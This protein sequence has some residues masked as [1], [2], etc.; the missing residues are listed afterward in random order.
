MQLE[1]KAGEDKLLLDI[2]NQH[3]RID[4]NADSGWGG[5]SIEALVPVEKQRLFVSAAVLNTKAKQIDDGLYAAAELIVQNG[6][7]K[8]S[9]K[10]EFL[11]K[12][13]TG[14]TEWS[15]PLLNGALHTIAACRL[16]GQKLGLSAELEKA[17]SLIEGGFVADSSS[18]K[19]I[20]FYTWSDELAQIFQQDRLLQQKLPVAAYRQVV[21]IIKDQ[22]LR[23][24]YLSYLAFVSKLTNPVV[25]AG[26]SMFLS[27][28]EATQFS[29]LEE[30]S[31]FPAST[32][33]ENE[34]MKK[35]FGATGRIPDGFDL[36]NEV[37]YRVR[38]GRI[39]LKPTQLSG[40]Y[41]HQLWSIEPLLIPDK[42]PES[43]RIVFRKGYRE[44]LEDLFKGLYALA[45]ETHAKQLESGMFGA[46]MPPQPERRKIHVI[47]QCTVEPLPSFY[48]RR[49]HS[50]KYLK[51]VLVE[52]L[53]EA[54]LKQHARLTERGPVKLN[55][56]EEL[57]KV[58]Q[59]F[60]GAHAQACFELGLPAADFGLGLDQSHCRKVLFDW[61]ASA[62]NDPD[63][64]QDMRMM[65]PVFFDVERKLT[66]V[67]LFMGWQSADLTV[68][69][70]HPPKVLLVN[71]EEPNEVHYELV[72]GSNSKRGA[73]PVFAEVYVD[74]LLNR[75]EFQKHCDKHFTEENIIANLPGAQLTSN[76]K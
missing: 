38:S 33:K 25:N 49:A 13:S 24:D 1:Q 10:R 44:K 46:A 74:K 7:G 17:V 9:S 8:I 60:Y 66:K 64:R 23:S 21:S 67:W 41:D 16:G 51:S 68:S 3:L 2:T 30:V 5:K 42:M 32:S 35:L 11:K 61:F 59:L 69:Y 48:L 36:M 14:L 6:S 76:P 55:I 70:D 28:P 57:D 52:Y 65:V 20:S 71:D 63:L 37:V 29:E 45:R 53:G 27:S 19:P 56:F 75:K 73:Y 31:F 39:D 18:S 34:L 12:L 50:Y 58:M 22:E 15:E 54:C 4:S 72:Y 40:W 47:P 62:S 26:L 43:A